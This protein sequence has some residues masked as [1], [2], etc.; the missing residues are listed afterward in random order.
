MFREVADYPVQALNWHD[1]TAWPSL[2]E[3]M[4]IFPGA[5]VGGVEQ[6]SLLH[7]GTPDEVRAQVQEALQ[8]TKGLRHIVAAGC[9]YPLTVPDGNLLAVRRAVEK[10]PSS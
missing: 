1:R 9:T 6:F 10:V 5:V 2:A 8:Q 4:A 3:A 7:L